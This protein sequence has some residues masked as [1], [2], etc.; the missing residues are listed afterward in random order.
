MTDLM[1][2]CNDDERRLLLQLLRLGMQVIWT[3]YKL[4][5]W[6]R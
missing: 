5:A 6:T 2:V 4:Q 3:G 1:F